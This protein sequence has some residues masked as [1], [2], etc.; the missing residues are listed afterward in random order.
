MREPT[1]RTQTTVTGLF[2]GWLYAPTGTTPLKVGPGGRAAI[3]LY[4]ERNVDKYIIQFEMNLSVG[5]STPNSHTWGRIPDH[6]MEYHL[7][8]YK[9]WSR[10]HF[11]TGASMAGHF[12]QDTWVRAQVYKLNSDNSAIHIRVTT[13]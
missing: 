2:S 13:S 4:H 9:P 6:Y 10:T 11:I 12:P 5:E 1:S 8:Q 7:G 3:Q